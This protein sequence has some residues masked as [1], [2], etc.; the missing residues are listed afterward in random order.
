MLRSI[1]SYSRLIP[2]A[3]RRQLV[4]G[5]PY[6]GREW[7]TATGELGAATIDSLGAVTYAA[8]VADLAS[9]N[10][11]KLF[12][13]GIKNPWYRW[14]SAGAWHEVYYDDAESLAA[15]YGLALAEDLGGIG[16]WALNYDAPHTELWDLLETSFTNLP[17]PPEGHR[18]HPIA[19]PSFPFQDARDTTVGPSQYFNYYSCAPSTP[20][21][22][23]EWV[24]RLDVCQPG[25]LVAKV[26]SYADRDPDLHLLSAPDQDACLA[27]DDTELSATVTAGQYLLVVDTYV[28]MPIELEGAYE[29][30]VDFTPEPGSVGC[31]PYLACLAGACVCATTGELDCGAG[32][33]DPATD[34]EHCGSCGVA[35]GLGEAC[36]GGECA[37]APLHAAGALPPSASGGCA[38]RLGP[39]S[40]RSTDGARA[41]LLGL[42][43]LAGLLS[44]RRTRSGRRRG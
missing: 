41:T 32:C 36:V 29:L 27:R 17:A 43:G 13:D 22:G 23:R 3:K 9:G 16:M 35:C 14:Q 8:S 42:V 19:I 26:P 10:V 5:V 40:A 28:Q 34:R 12:D 38:C 39:A 7:V 1:A 24:Y 4:W 2:A 6:Y 44:A 37:P 30:D 25:T 11:E 31:A 33:V 21:Y 18:H 20:E 15:K